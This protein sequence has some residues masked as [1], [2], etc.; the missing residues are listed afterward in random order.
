MPGILT[1]GLDGS[2]QS[3][4][5]LDWAAHEALRNGQE[6]RLLHAC[7][8]QPTDMAPVLAGRA[9]EEEW[10]RDVLAEAAARAR[11]LGPGLAVSTEVVTAPPVDALLTASVDSD[12]LVLGSRALGAL[13]GYLIGSVAL[14]VLR[15]V[16][17]PVVLVRRPR[18]EGRNRP[19]DVVVV[20]VD[21]TEAPGAEVLEFA[22]A[23]AAARGLPLRAVRAW[24][25][26]TMFSAE[27]LVAPAV[28]AA[29]GLEAWHRQLL[30][31][32]LQALRE[33]YP[34]VEVAEHVEIGSP[35]QVLLSQSGD[36]A[37]LV[38]GRH[39]A[40]HPTPRRIGSTTHALLHH[41][42]APVAVVPL[43]A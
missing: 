40:A 11:R 24:A 12:V 13:G 39:R 36:A 43:S 25:L 4:A 5:A 15:Q 9:A 18:A 8:W 28:D 30:T 38:V 34:Q 32:A 21:D 37:L 16:T 22:F 33:R 2:E 19:K 17:R 10:A 14:H 7:F 31:E 3:L 23:A 6:L 26:P 42:P 20:G 35:S 1:V 29:G 27:P 41:S